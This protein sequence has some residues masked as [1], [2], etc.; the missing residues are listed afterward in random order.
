VC[1]S[2]L[3]ALLVIRKQSNMYPL[4]RLVSEVF[5]VAKRNLEPGEVLDAIGGCTF[6]GLIDTYETAKAERLL[7]IGLAKGARVCRPIA[8]DQPITLDDVELH[9]PSTVLTLRRLQDAWMDG[10]ISEADLL[11]SVEALTQD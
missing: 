11:A 10:K 1:S 2:D 9:E 3:C 4:D 6:Y 7:P 8:V 5:A